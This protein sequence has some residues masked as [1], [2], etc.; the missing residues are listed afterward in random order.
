NLGDMSPRAIET[1]R[2][3]DLIAAE[4]TRHS[5]K[6]L[7]H[8][9][10][11]TQLTSLHEHNEQGKSQNL[12]RRMAEEGISIALISDAGTPA[13][14]DPGALFVKAAAQAGIEVVTIPG[15]SAAI[16][17]LSISGFENSSFT[18]YGFLPRDLKSLRERLKSMAGKDELAILHESPFR[19]RKLL[20]TILESLGDLPAS[21]SCDLSKLHE[22]TLRGTVSQILE[23][24]E[25]NEKAEKGEYVLV[26]DVSGVQ[27]EAETQ[28]EDIT[29]EAR[30]LDLLLQGND[31]QHAM[32]ELIARGERKNALYAASLRL[33]TLLK[34]N[35]VHLISDL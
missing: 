22:L 34:E 4:D 21:L 35:Y 16:A 20:Q 23:A 14:Y 15:P 32:S 31:L 17:A 13:I 27:A 18:F 9:Q 6:L 30:L 1:L 19:V 2:E 26:L 12:V 10:I 11:H 3:V 5:M 8:F 7:N 24:F 28:D 33:K 29:L 25:A